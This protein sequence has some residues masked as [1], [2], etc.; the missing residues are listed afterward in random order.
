M[1]KM[2]RYFNTAG[3]II[4]TS[5]NML[6]MDIQFNH[7]CGYRGEKNDFYQNVSQIEKI[8]SFLLAENN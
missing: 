1:I 6:E 8:Y 5:K 3:P 2:E 4:E 7:M